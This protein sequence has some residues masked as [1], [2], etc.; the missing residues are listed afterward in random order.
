MTYREVLR[1]PWW[2]YAVAIGLAAL[3]C[4]TFAAAATV[5]AALVLFV[6]L[7]AVA[8]WVVSRRRLEISVDDDRLRI[9]AET[10]ARDSIADVL[11]LH[12][13]QM[14]D[15]A[16]PQADPRAHLILRNLSTKAGVKIDVGA[17]PAPY[18]L[19][20][21]AHPEELVAALSH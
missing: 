10:L 5:P 7:A 6:I 21:S 19:V 20:S 12:A 4:F 13:E 11:A 8:S 9:G 16:G 2:V 15:V 14:R 17:G 1:P 3:F 18:W